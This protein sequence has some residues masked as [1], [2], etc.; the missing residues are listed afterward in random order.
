M[1]VTYVVNVS[2]FKLLVRWQARCLTAIAKVRVRHRGGIEV[3]E[4]N[5]HVGFH[6]FGILLVWWTVR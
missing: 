3:I 2:V 6:G 4:V 1:V 5:S